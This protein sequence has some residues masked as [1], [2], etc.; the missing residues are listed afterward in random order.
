MHTHTCLLNIIE[1]TLQ[2]VCRARQQL[3]TYDCDTPA[4]GDAAVILLRL[5]RIAALQES[6]A[7]IMCPKDFPG[8]L[9]HFGSPLQC[10]EWPHA[11]VQWQQLPRPT[12]D[13]RREPRRDGV[14]SQDDHF[15]C[16][17]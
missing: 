17:R 12:T 15:L 16:L 5:L 14:S 11:G 13:L 8:I 6:A 9:H 10:W 1:K 3:R 7:A 2:T 4:R